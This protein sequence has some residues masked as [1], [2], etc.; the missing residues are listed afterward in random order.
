MKIPIY[1]N[2]K[3][4]NIKTSIHKTLNPLKSHKHIQILENINTKLSINN[5]KSQRKQTNLG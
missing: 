5:L 1:F 2:L 3:C 4:I